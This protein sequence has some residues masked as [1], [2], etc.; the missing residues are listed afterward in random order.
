MSSYNLL[1]DDIRNPEIITWVKG[2]DHKAWE[3]IVV[4]SY[5]EFCDYISKHGLPY[6]VSFDHDL[7]DEHYPWNNEDGL[8][9]YD[10][11]KEKTGYDAAKWMC[12]YCT[13]QGLRLPKVVVHTM[14]PI[15]KENIEKF[16]ESYERS[17]TR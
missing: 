17:I 5:D 4:R 16:I 3:W 13:N 14:N 11:Y 10:R 2:F 7:A 15:G 8:P 1:L 9:R 6:I 12:Y